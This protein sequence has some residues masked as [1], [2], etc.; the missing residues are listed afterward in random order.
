MQPRDLHRPQKP[1]SPLITC[2]RGGCLL[3][4]AGLAYAALQAQP[5]EGPSAVYEHTPALRPVGPAQEVAP[6][7]PASGVERA[8]ERA[9]G[10]RPGPREQR[11]SGMPFAALR[12]R[13]R[14]GSLALELAGSA[15]N[16][17]DDWTGASSCVGAAC[18]T[19]GASYVLLWMKGNHKLLAPG[20]RGVVAASVAPSL[21]RSR[22]RSLSLSRSRSRSLSLSLSLSLSPTPTRSPTSGACLSSVWHGG[23]WAPMAAVATAAMVVAAAAAAAAAVVAAVAAAVAA[24]AAGCDSSTCRAVSGCG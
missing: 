15:C 22:S 17:T 21:S 6:S 4:V 24:A 23:S 19:V 18:N 10:R 5:A 3:L 14:N 2:L 1:T 16:A 11:E 9:F 8:F 12:D 13:A 7:V 20:E